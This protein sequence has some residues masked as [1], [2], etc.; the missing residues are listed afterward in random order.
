VYGLTTATSGYNYGGYFQTASTAG[1]GVYGVANTNSGANY[2]GFFVTNSTQGR[3]VYGG[4]T[5]TSGNN[6]GGYFATASIE[7]RAVYGGATATSG[8]NYGGYFQTASTSGRG[9]YGRAYAT[10][11][12][13]CGGDFETA[14]TEGKAVF[15]FATAGSGSTYGVYGGVLSAAGYGV[16]SY[17]R[18]GATGTKSFQIDHPSDPENKYLNHYCTEGSEPLN[19][20]SGN[21]LLDAS[22]EAVVELPSYFELINKDFRYQLTALDA[23]MPDL[24][25]AERI[26]SNRFKIAGGKPGM[27]VSWRVEAVRNDRWVE[28]YG[29]PVEIDKPGGHRSKYLHPELYGQPESMGVFYEPER[30]VE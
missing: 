28:K 15:G 19:V 22:G 6:Y 18:F 2:G 8:Y 17:G 25:V 30:K 21:V 24:H 5:A 1:R 16:Y 29:A 13:T 26:K 23:A 4:A 14:S 9:V 7:G 20:Y 27:E 10:S 11:G 3:G 12:S